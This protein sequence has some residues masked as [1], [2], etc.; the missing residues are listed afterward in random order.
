MVYA[1][2]ELNMVFA[3]E[4]QT[5]VDG[6]CIFTSCRIEKMSQFLVGTRNYD[7][8]TILQLANIILLGIQVR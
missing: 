6:R 7:I 2:T 1:Y 5:Y 8:F 3:N 4:G